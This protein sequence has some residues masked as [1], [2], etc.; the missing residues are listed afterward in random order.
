MN[1]AFD[2]RKLHKTAVCSDWIFTFDGPHS[3]ER[4]HAVHTG[5]PTFSAQQIIT[6]DLCSTYTHW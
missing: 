2:E 3:L 5:G 4:C 6:T 1:L